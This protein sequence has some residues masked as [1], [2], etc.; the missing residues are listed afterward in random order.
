MKKDLIFILFL[1]LSEDKIVIRHIIYIKNYFNLINME[2]YET[3]V[4][5]ADDEN[6]I[7]GFDQDI[8]S[9]SN[10]AEEILLRQDDVF[11]ELQKFDDPELNEAMRKTLNTLS[12]E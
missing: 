1:I 11:E 5:R 9:G 4:Q 3:Y 2:S 8:N 6:K 7:L 12:Q 10:L